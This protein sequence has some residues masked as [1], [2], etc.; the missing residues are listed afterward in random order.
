[1]WDLVINPDI[2]I[3][4]KK[5]IVKKSEVRYIPFKLHEMSEKFG[6]QSNAN[7]LWVSLKYRV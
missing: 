6:V 2:K 1:M 5:K 4:K 3:W 7:W